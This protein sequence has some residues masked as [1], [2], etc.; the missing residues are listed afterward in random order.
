[1]TRQFT[2]FSLNDC[3][4]GIDIQY[5]DEITRPPEIVP[6]AGGPEFVTGLMNLRGQIITVLDIGMR[7]GLGKTKKDDRSRCI[8]L[9]TDAQLKKA[10]ASDL[11]P[12]SLGE[13]KIALL[14]DRIDDLISLDQEAL[15]GPPANLK[16]IDPGQ[17]EKVAQLSNRLLMILALERLIAKE[18]S[19]VS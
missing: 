10:V 18:K 19:N 11:N 6:V 4:F 8:V 15:A 16:E 9:K 1:M 12:V 14:V 3:L 17:V 5:V 13:D 7:L 2:T